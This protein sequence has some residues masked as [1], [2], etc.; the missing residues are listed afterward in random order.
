[1]VDDEDDFSL[2][3]LFFEYIFWSNF[4]FGVIMKM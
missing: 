1:M 4:F 3:F 2:V